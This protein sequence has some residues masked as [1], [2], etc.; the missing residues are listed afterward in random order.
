MKGGDLLSRIVEKEAYTEAEARATCRHVFEA[1]RYCHRKR[2]AHRDIKLDNLLLVV[3]R[4]T[5]KDVVASFPI[6]NL[7]RLV[8]EE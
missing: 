5:W 7:C 1:V 8:G 6:S 3:S 4:K 2:I